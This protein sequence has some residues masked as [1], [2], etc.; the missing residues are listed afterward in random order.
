[1]RRRRGLDAQSRTQVGRAGVRRI[2]RCGDFGGRGVVVAV[3]LN[4][5]HVPE[6]GEKANLDSMPDLSVRAEKQAT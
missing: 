4:A 3:Q 1:M 6:A 5:A 2:G